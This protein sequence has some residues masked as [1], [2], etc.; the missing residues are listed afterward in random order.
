[1]TTRCG[2]GGDVGVH[3]WCWGA[4][5]ACQ[6]SLPGVM[7]ACAGP[8]RFVPDVPHPAGFVLPPVP[9]HTLRS[10]W[11][12]LPPSTSRPVLGGPDKPEHPEPSTLLCS[13]CSGLFSGSP[14]LPGALPNLALQRAGGTPEPTCQIFPGSAKKSPGA[15]VT[16]P[17]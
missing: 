6:A 9:R 16:K 4:I 17:S 15:P 13:T 7:T 8:A 3:R 14:L 1:M 12:P 11:N 2:C 5:P 10:F